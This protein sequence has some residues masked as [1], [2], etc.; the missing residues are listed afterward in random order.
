MVPMHAFWDWRLS[1]NRPIGARAVAS[2]DLPPLPKMRASP[3]AQSRR[4][5]TPMLALRMALPAFFFPRSS[6]ERKRSHANQRTLGGPSSHFESTRCRQ[7]R[8]EAGREPDRSLHPRQARR[9]ESPALT[10]SRQT[11]TAEAGHFD[12]TG[13][14][15]ARKKLA[16][17]SDPSPDAFDRLLT[18]LNSPRYG[19]RWRAIGWTPFITLTVMG[20]TKTGPDKFVALSRLCHPRLQRRQTLRALCRGTDR[21]R[22]AVSRRSQRRHCHGP[23]RD[24]SLG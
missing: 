2:R 7:P 8:T 22:C 18:S 19:E 9:E 3:R 20:M 16:L 1:M 11:H 14:C 24:R 4:F 17:S 6:F 13:C 23:H 12:L 15:P 10:G 21:G 5:M